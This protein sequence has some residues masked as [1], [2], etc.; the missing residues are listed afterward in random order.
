L[1]ELQVVSGALTKGN[2]GLIL[3]FSFPKGSFF[4]VLEEG[5]IGVIPSLS[6]GVLILWDWNR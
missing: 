5:R 1:K 2:K 6:K 4:K 3:F